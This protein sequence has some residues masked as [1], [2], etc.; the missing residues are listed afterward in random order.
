MS[1]S[2]LCRAD[3][4]LRL[5]EKITS[6]LELKC[7]TVAAFLDISKAY[8]STWHTRLIYKL[9]QMNPPG[10]LIRVI[11]S[12]LAHRS[13]RVKM[14]KAVSGWRPMLVGVR[15]GST[16][17]PLLYNLCTSDIPLSART[18][19]SVY[20]DGI[21]IYH[22]NTSAQFVH[23]AVQRHLYKIG[24][25]ANEWCININAKKT[26]AVV[27]SK[28]ISLQL[29]VLKLH[30]E[31]IEYVPR[32]LYLGVFLDRRMNWKPTLKH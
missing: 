13:F 15:Q 8:D 21:F 18:E 3:Q 24:R 16:L 17:S 31:D 6:G 14:D 11:D 20:A 2:V 27:F 30:G 19:L 32:C 12:V 7:S 1:S 25:W 28:R 10:E 29:P 23:L 5:T 22:K 4:L 9:I 26:K